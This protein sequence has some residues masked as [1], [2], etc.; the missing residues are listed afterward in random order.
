MTVNCHSQR[1]AG[2]GILP[3]IAMTRKRVMSSTAELRKEHFEHP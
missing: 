2:G 3:E 1:L